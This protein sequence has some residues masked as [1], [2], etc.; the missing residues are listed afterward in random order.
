MGVAAEW[1]GWGGK[2]RLLN[3]QDLVHSTHRIWSTQ[4]TGFGPL[5][6]TGFDPLNAQDLVDCHKVPACIQ[7]LAAPAVLRSVFDLERH[8]VDDPDA[9]GDVVPDDLSHVAWWWAKGASV[10]ASART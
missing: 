10:S 2:Q 6:R 1:G 7:H 8:K 4:R 5:K 3:A 9:Q